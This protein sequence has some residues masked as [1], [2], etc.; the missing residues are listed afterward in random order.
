MPPEVAG[1]K[2]SFLISPRFLLSAGRSCGRET[3]PALSTK[4][5]DGVEPSGEGEGSSE[6]R[7]APLALAGVEASPAGRKRTRIFFSW[8]D[9]L[10]VCSMCDHYT[11]TLA[12]G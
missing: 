4:P 3:E 5:R 1:L 7:L 8:I 12:R 2:A 11:G 9:D 6:S 10:A